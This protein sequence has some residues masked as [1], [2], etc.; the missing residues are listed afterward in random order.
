[1]D[2]AYAE[3]LLQLN[4]VLVNKTA[5]L[6]KTCNKLKLQPPEE[7]GKDIDTDNSQG[8]MPLSP[9]APGKE[10]RHI[11]WRLLAI[12]A[13]LTL[14]LSTVVYA[15]AAIIYSMEQQ[16][17]EYFDRS[18]MAQTP[19][20]GPTYHGALAMDIEQYN[21]SVGTS[22]T[23]NGK[24]VTLDTIAV[25]DNFINAFFTITYDKPIDLSAS[26]AIDNSMPAYDKL[27]YV[28]PYFTIKVDGKDLD[29]GFTTI[30]ELDPYM[31]N[32]HT[33]KMLVRH[34]VPTIL[35]NE[36]KLSLS[37]EGWGDD[38]GVYQFEVLVDKTA[39]ATKTLAATPG[40]YQLNTT[41]GQRTLDLEKLSITP[42]GGIF[43]VKGHWNGEIGPDSNYLMPQD[44][45]IT[46]D[47]GNA[48][49]TF[50]NNG[51][52]PNS[53]YYAVEIIN[54]AP[55]TKSITLTPI[56]SKNSE[57]DN[58]TFKTYSTNDIGTK[59]ETNPY[60][61]FYLEDYIVEDKRISYVL[62]PYGLCHYTT[63]FMPDDDNIT[64]LQGRS[65]LVN[66]QID[67]KTGILTYSID[68]YA[69]T[70]QELKAITSFQVAYDKNFEL[71]KASEITLP[72]APSAK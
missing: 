38:T 46:D 33:V 64:L 32:D 57:G 70:L 50:W 40:A 5:I 11:T 28:L 58:V 3:D 17:V 54:P 22:V 60:G 59:I 16:K 62:R 55:D 52:S 4:P 27:R 71:D 24:T 13:V 31:Q 10:K 42:F 30:D 69:A 41:N 21:A 14:A 43:S 8:S 6:Q 35:P 26:S 48:L 63:D 72:L 23:D 39:S 9:K 25:D 56:I 29:S 45:Y 19:V 12:A 67:R 53:P 15:A 37:G 7:E 2:E 61:G 36:F 1:M 44:F 51:V 18:S 66:Q 47:K 34:T 20:S 68:Y 65:G 49:N